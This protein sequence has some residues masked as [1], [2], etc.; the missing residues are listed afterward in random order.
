MRSR[1]GTEKRKR[2]KTYSVRLSDEEQVKARAIVNHT[3][4]SLAAYIRHKIFDAP[5]P[6]AV[7]R[8]PAELKAVVQLLGELGRIGSNVNQLAKHANAGR[9]QINSV[10]LAMQTLM[11]MRTACME[12]LGREQP[13]NSKPQDQNP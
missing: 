8:P 3:G 6:R 7:R 9:I 12:A 13:R 11:E 4:L 10:D 5:L 2:S 1:S